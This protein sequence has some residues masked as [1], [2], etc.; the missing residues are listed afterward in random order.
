[1]NFGKVHADFGIEIKDINI[2][3]VNEILNLFEKYLLIK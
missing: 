2:N 3:K 1:M